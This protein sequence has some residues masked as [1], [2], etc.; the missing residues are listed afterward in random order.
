MNVLSKTLTVL[1]LVCAVSF[2]GCGRRMIGSPF[3]SGFTPS[4]VLAK[5]GGPAG[6]QYNP[7]SAGSSSS[8]RLFGGSHIQRQWLLSAKDVPGKLQGQMDQ[9]QTE[10]EGMLTA[11]SGK[12]TGRDKRSGTDFCS[13][14]LD[15]ESG[16]AKGVIRVI[17]V[18]ASSGRMNVDVFVY[19]Y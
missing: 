14:T 19:E 10:I 3:L 7:G 13:F 17:G 1:L 8:S 9:F 16:A 15:Y 18:S 6:I 2:T 4:S 11:L 5:I 12:V